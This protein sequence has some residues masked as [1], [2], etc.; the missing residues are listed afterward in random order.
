MFLVIFAFMTLIGS[1]YFFERAM[2]MTFGIL[3]MTAV[4]VLALGML[5]DLIN[6]RI[7]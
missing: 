3:V 5:A 6:K 1:Q 2:D 4:M 7:K